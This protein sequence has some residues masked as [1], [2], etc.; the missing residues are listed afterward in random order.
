MESCALAHYGILGQKWGIRRFQNKDGTRTAAGKKRAAE[1]SD[2]NK[3]LSDDELRQRVNRLQLEKQ[4]REL[5]ESLNSKKVSKGKSF[6]MGVLERSGS[7]I[8]TQ[9]VTYA[10]GTAVNKF[11]GKNIVN[12]KKGQKDK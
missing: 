11:F 12:P 10:M 4:Y 2:K 5:S 1:N 7:N 3:E 9:A 6:V 8:A